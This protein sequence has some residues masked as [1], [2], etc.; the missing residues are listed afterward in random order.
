MVMIFEDF[1]L[2][3]LKFAYPTLFKGCGLSTDC[4]GWK[5]FYLSYS[6][7][8]LVNYRASF[9]LIFITFYILVKD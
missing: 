2:V 9:V 7:E 8:E 3:L 4:C 5:K 1:L 6:G